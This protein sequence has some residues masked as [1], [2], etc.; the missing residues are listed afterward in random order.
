[1]V[2]CIPTIRSIFRGSRWQNLQIEHE[3]YCLGHLI[4]AGI[5]HHA[6]TG[7]S[8]LLNIAIRAADLLVASFMEASPYYTDGHEEIEIA[9]MRLSRHTKNSVYKELA[10][11]FLERR[12]RIPAYWF[13]FLTQTLRTAG[14]MKAVKKM[15]TVYESANPEN[16]THRMPASNRHRQHWSLP[17]R[18]AASALTGKYTHQHA[19]LIP[20]EEPVGHAVRFA[21]LNTAA[22]MLALDE[23]DVKLANH[24]ADSWQHMV[25]RRMY[26]TGGIGSLPLLEG[27]GRDYELDPEIAYAETCAALGSIFWSREMSAITRDARYEDLVEWQLYNAASVGIGLDGRSTFTITR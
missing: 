3:F 15:R 20:Q 21:Y 12:G 8:D 2:T 22:A 1:M 25:T 19:P 27:F 11:R 7:R 13:H 18:F 9:L 17:L 6:A 5:A 10:R 24:L 16:K 26:V 23:K 14:R 4:E